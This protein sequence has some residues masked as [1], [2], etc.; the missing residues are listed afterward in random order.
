MGHFQVGNRGEWKIELK[1]NPVG[2]PVFGD[3]HASF[4]SCEK[5][6]FHLGVLSHYSG[7]GAVRN[8]FGDIGPV[9]SIVGSLVD[10]RRVIVEFVAGSRDVCR[11]RIVR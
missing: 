3:I 9:L 8:A 7:K 2:S 1:G 6:I 10:R 4:C 5:K 11:R